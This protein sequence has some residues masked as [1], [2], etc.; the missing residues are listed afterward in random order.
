MPAEGRPDASPPS[1]PASRPPRSTAGL[2]GPVVLLFALVFLLALVL[3]FC[4]AAAGKTG[5]AGFSAG[6]ASTSWSGFAVRAEAPDC[7]ANAG[8]T[9][10]SIVTPRIV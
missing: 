1:E 7:C 2:G 4:G 6:R 10:A 5:C 8:V 3:T 9:S